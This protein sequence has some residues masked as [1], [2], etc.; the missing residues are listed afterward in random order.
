MQVQQ[1]LL[2]LKQALH[3]PMQL[4]YLLA[5]SSVVHAQALVQVVDVICSPGLSRGL[6]LSVLVASPSA[7]RPPLL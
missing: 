6:R 2:L 5:V 3:C 7:V 1:G 4:Y